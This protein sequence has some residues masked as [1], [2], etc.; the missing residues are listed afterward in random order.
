MKKIFEFGKIDFCRRGRKCNAVTVEMEYK[1][2][3]DKKRFSVSA[4]VWNNTRTDIV[5][6]GQC[7]DSIAPFIHDKRFTEILRLWKLYHLNDMHPECEHQ[8]AQ[9]WRKQAREKATLYIFTLTTETITA[10]NSLKR[11]ILT[12]EALAKRSKAKRRILGDAQNGETVQAS[13][14]ERKV[15]ALSYTLES[16]TA[17]LPEDIAPY[18]QADGEKVERRGW[19]RYEEDSRG[20]LGKPCP[21]CGYKYGHGWQYFPIPEEDEKI[22]I[23]LLTGE[24]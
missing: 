14:E 20:I 3:G 15:L 8:A 2:E 4:S 23:G 19:L 7:L 21:V 10:Q 24:G 17:D 1:E 18:Y 13:P 22:I 16:A 5:A 9:G 11:R 6:G 12:N